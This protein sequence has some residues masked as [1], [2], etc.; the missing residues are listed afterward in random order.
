MSKKNDK[1]LQYIIGNN[2]RKERTQR[3]MSRDELADLLGV[4]VGHIGLMER[5]ERGVTSHRLHKLCEIFHVPEGRFFSDD[6]KLAEEME[7]PTR[8]KRNK[9]ISLLHNLSEPE[10]DM[11]ISTLKIQR[12]FKSQLLKNNQIADIQDDYDDIEDI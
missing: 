8:A 9:I 5:G 3:N 6:L 12:D 1:E 4:T 10:L 7:S 11:V 2:I